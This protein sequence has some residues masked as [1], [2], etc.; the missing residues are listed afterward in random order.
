MSPSL[1]SQSP[2]VCGPRPGTTLAPHSQ[3]AGPWPTA[4]PFLHSIHLPP[5]PRT[6][7]SSGSACVSVTALR[8]MRADPDPTVS[9]LATQ[10]S[11]ILEAK[12]K[13]WVASSTSCFCPRRLRKA[14]F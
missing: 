12:E 13:T 4:L 8:H 14:C 3:A 6:P 11:Y 10:T 1:A 2:A 7:R 5:E 9:C